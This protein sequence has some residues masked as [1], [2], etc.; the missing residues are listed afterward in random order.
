MTVITPTPTPTPSILA[1]AEDLPCPVNETQ[2]LPPLCLQMPLTPEATTFRGN[3]TAAPPPPTTTPPSSPGS[4]PKGLATVQAG[5]SPVHV[6]ILTGQPL[7]TSISSALEKICPAVSQTESMTTC[8]TD[9]V[10]IE[11]ISYTKG[12]TLEDDGELDV[13][14]ASSSYNDTGL[15]DAMIMAAA[16]TANTSAQGSSCWQIPMAQGR[17]RER[18]LTP[19]SFWTDPFRIR[20]RS[21]LEK[22]QGFVAY[23][24][25]FSGQGGQA[26]GGSGNG[27][28]TLCNA[29]SF[30]GVQYYNQWWQQHPG[31]SSWLDA[32]W[33][34]K[35]GT[36]GDSTC[37]WIQ[38]LISALGLIAPEF[39]VEDIPLAEAIGVLCTEAMDHA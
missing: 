38:D 9:P 27:G 10:T 4:G 21:E 37:E 6:G 17:L 19:W 2:G 30:A 32:S 39:A 11:G 31:S 34:F 26:G 7:Y 16:L 22:R 5:S 18:E 23:A 12:Q 33:E 24:G 14:V 25:P 20:Y 3:S 13:K 35:A 8:A 1:R 36:S 29:A 15:R 28:L